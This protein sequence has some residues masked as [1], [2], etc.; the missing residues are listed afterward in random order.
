MFLLHP[1]VLAIGF[2][3]ARQASGVDASKV[4]APLFALGFLTFAAI[5]SAIPLVPSLA[6]AIMPI[7]STLIEA[8][9]WG[10]MLA[11]AALGL[12]TTVTSLLSVGW[13]R[14]SIAVGTTLV[15][16]VAATLGMAIA[17]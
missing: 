6:P 16:L 14:I 9:N 15:I 5:N 11:I 8:S 1:I 3:F 7:K 12:G 13:R 4:P 17:A 10:M 2:Y